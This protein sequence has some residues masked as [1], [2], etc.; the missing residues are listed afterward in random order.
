[1]LGLLV[2]AEDVL[3]LLWLLWLQELLAQWCG[4]LR[5]LAQRTPS[6][7]TCA[8]LC[9]HRLQPATSTSTDLTAH[10]ADPHGV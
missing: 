3:W 5:Q 4:R 7:F 9:S 6:D 8:V 2:Q 10:I 1:M